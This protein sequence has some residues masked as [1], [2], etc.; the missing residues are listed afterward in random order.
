MSKLSPYQ[1]STIEI[2]RHRIV[3]VIFL[4]VG[5]VVF[6]AATW[7]PDSDPSDRKRNS[8]SQDGQTDRD[9]EKPA[10]SNHKA[11][12]S[13]ANDWEA[14]VGKVEQAFPGSKTP[15]MARIRERLKFL[16]QNLTRSEL[17]EDACAKIVQSLDALQ[18]QAAK[19]SA[20]SKRPSIN[21]EGIDE[22]IAASAQ[23]LQIAEQETTRLARE[24]AERIVRRE[25]EPVIRRIRLAKQDQ[26]DQ[27]IELRRRI[28]EMQRERE[29]SSAK[30]A[31]ENALQNE[32]RDVEKFLQPFTAPGNLQP[33]SDSNPWDVERTFDSKP[34][35]LA[36]LQRLGALEQTMEGL[37]RLYIFGGGKNPTVNN[38]RPLGSFP[39][40]WAQKLKK[41]HIL[42]P[43]KRAQ[44]LL[45]D[46]GQALVE[47]QL[48]SP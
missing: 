18:Q 23:S 14:K 28:A 39:E 41:P 42:Q 35:S 21:A 13:V 25:R 31:R 16:S 44:Q 34:V 27:A 6:L 46:H 45:R 37:E 32:M 12:Y 7:I 36:R 3:T 47:Q 9:D 4:V 8:L 48:L 29:E 22:A 30:S 43:V 19:L 40:Y 26:L 2:G 5:E 1:R 33:N 20:I 24:Q 38:P 11:E 17:S 15:E 10:T